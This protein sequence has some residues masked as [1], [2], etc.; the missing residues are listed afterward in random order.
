MRKII[1]LPAV[2]DAVGKSATTIYNEEKA[3]KFPKRVQIGPNA[4]GWFA[5]EI[6]E[7]QESR[8]RGM[9]PA[10]QAAI[11]AKQGAA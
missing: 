7:Y 3:G 9:C 5:D 2:I 10:P 1:R 4:V 6:E 8:P 11:A